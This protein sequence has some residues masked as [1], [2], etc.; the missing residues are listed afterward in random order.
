MTDKWCKLLK[1]P[2]QKP[3]I[4]IRAE[5]KNQ[6]FLKVSK[7]RQNY[8]K[9]LLELFKNKQTCSPNK[10]QIKTYVGTWYTLNLLYKKHSKKLPSLDFAFL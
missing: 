1:Y 4:D 9:D 3:G 10:A 7:F 6:K 2:I 8:L 5:T